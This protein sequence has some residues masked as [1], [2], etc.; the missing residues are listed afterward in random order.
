MSRRAHIE[1]IVRRHLGKRIMTAAP[2]LVLDG[3]YET[4]VQRLA[5][6]LCA[7]VDRIAVLEAELDKWKGML[8][9]SEQRVLADKL[10][11]VMALWQEALDQVAA[12]KL[13]NQRL[14]FRAGL[15]GQTVVER[16][17][18]EEES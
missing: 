4:T 8:T 16:G 17:R 13:D 2:A 6:A 1:T 10:P 5:D 15:D 7:P 9:A 18:G 12:L 3:D 14:D 11:V